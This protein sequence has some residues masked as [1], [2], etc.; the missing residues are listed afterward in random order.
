M[1][2]KTIDTNCANFR[3]EAQLHFKPR[4]NANREFTTEARRLRAAG[5]KNLNAKPQGCEAAEK[6]K[7]LRA[8]PCR[9][10]LTQRRGASPSVYQRDAW[11]RRAHPVESSRY[12]G[13]RIRIR[14]RSVG[15]EHVSGQ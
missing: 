13:A 15:R 3:K 11:L 4:M 1:G 6:A 10:V 7:S 14:K 12:G 8:K 5:K 9:Q 2:T